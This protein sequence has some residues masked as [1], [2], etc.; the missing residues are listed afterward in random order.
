MILENVV[1]Y[2]KLNIGFLVYNKHIIKDDI[3]LEC[4]KQI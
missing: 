1:I 3:Y 2:V 4:K